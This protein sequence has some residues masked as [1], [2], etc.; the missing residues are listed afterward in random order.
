MSQALQILVTS[1]RG[2]TLRGTLDY[3]SSLTYN[4][5]RPVV[6]EIAAQVAAGQDRGYVTDEG[7]AFAWFSAD[8]FEIRQ[9]ADGTW[10]V[11]DTVEQAKTHD[12]YFP[13]RKGAEAELDAI[14]TEAASS[15]R[16]SW[17]RVA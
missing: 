15:G 13:A 1:S 7:Q 10:Y 4:L 12:G 16:D 5:P 3:R 11:F 17:S 2:Q 9:A 6:T 8:I 14:F